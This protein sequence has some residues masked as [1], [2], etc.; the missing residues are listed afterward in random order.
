MVNIDFG[1][2]SDQGRDGQ[3]SSATLINAYVEIIQ[4]PYGKT[5]TPVYVCP[6]LTRWDNGSYVGAIRGA[7]WIRNVGLF[8]VLGNELIQWLPASVSVN[9]GSIAGTGPVSMAANQ[10]QVGPQIGIITNTGAYYVADTAIGAPVVLTTP[11]DP[12]APIGD[13]LPFSTFPAPVS[14]C[15][16]SNYFMFAIPDGRIFMSDLNDA[17]VINPLAYDLA[18]TSSNGLVRAV[19]HRGVLIVMGPKSYEVWQNAGTYPFAFAPIPGS[20]GVGLLA[21]DSVVETDDSLLWVD[22]EGKVQMTTGSYPERISNHGVERAIA[23]LTLGQKQALRAT[24]YFFQGHKFYSL[25]SE[26][27]WTWEYDTTTKL[28]HQRETY[29]RG[30]WIGCCGTQVYDSIIM[31]NPDNGMLYRVSGDSYLDGSDGFCVTA[32]GQIVHAFPD[33]LIV[34]RIRVDAARGTGGTLILSWSDDGGRTWQGDLEQSLGDAGDYTIRVDFRRIGA[35]R[36]P[37]RLFRF[38]SSTPAFRALMNVDAS[39]RKLTR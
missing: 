32:I 26:G 10:R 23:A 28:W 2:V 5:Q 14:V 6:G 19:A 31:G 24:Y 12:P 30:S 11:L 25:T 38:V 36:E 35:V 39:V 37:G 16:I 8:T 22:H 17:N 9:W 33:G 1:H 18:Q 20:I 3:I 29:G 27:N 34:D 7:L 4:Q 15:C 21:F 13:G